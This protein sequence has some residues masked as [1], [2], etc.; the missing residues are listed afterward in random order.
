M[1]RCMIVVFWAFD[2]VGLLLQRINFKIL[3]VFLTGTN[4]MIENMSEIFIILFLIIILVILIII[5]G[6]FKTE[7][8]GRVGEAKVAA[9]LYFLDR[10]KY[11]VINN[12]VL[13]T[14]EK[15]SQI[16]HLVI[17]DFGIFVI[18]TKNYKGWI[19]GGENAEYWTQVLFRKKYKLYNPIRQNMSHIQ[20]LKHNL[21]DFPQ[22]KYISVIVFSSKATIK[23][24]TST[25]VVYTYKLLNAIG[26][27][28][29]ICV[30]EAEKHEIFE[31]INSINSKNIYS[32]NSH[33]ESI[34]SG[35]RKR[36]KSI[37][38]NVCPQCG[39]RL[40]SRQ[41]KFGNFLGCSSFPKCKF[42]RNF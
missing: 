15:V 13:Y 27:H 41:G 34:Q 19:V 26:Q 6:I 11:K 32:K 12:V 3:S 21:P 10:S 5:S 39:S 24:N 40:V 8:K 29:N 23:V 33:I 16:D 28:S 20:A 37:A 31:K 1:H 18:E 35:I 17:S 4:S 7:I 25:D 36:E 2:R 22:L 9:I 38:Q 14:K 30:T 42:T